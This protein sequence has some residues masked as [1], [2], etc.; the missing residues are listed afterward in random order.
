MLAAANN[1]MINACPVSVA[2]Q[3]VNGSNLLDGLI[4]SS[5]SA[6]EETGKM[7]ELLAKA[8]VFYLK[9]VRTN[10]RKFENKISVIVL[11]PAA[12]AIGIMWISI[13]MPNVGLFNMKF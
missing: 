2:L 3:E 13:I 8:E 1:I 7:D 5:I 9:V 12:A 11:V 10:L 6:G 4:V